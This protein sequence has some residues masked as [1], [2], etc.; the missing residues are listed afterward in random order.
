M[1]AAQ[2]LKGARGELEVVEL[3]RVRWPRATRNF[4]SGAAGNGDIAHG[5]AGVLIEC[6]HTERLRLRDAWAQAAASADAAGLTPVVAARWNG[7]PWLAVLELDE[8]LALF[9][10]RERG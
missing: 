7:G 6:K 1:S 10:L 9:D 8:V 2:R 3:I 4:A 5:P